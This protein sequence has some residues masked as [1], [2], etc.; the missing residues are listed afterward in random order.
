MM[1]SQVQDM[2]KGQ[3]QAILEGQTQISELLREA[4]STGH[5]NLVDVERGLFEGLL[6][7]GRGALEAYVAA[8]GDGDLGQTVEHE[9]KVLQRLDARSKR[10][11]S[12]FGEITIQRVVYATREGQ[13]HELIPLD[14]V[15][16]L[17]EGDFSHLLQSWDQK[18]CVQN[19]FDRSRLA[20]EEILG[21]G[22]SVR[23]LE[24]MN[25]SMASCAG[26]FR[27]AQAPPPA[28]EEGEILVLTADGKGIPMKRESSDPAPSGRRTKGQ[29]ANK[30]RMACVGAVYSI[31]RFRRTARTVVDDVLRNIRS[32]DRPIP[33]HKQ[34]RAELTREING[35]EC[36]GKD[37]TIGWLVDQVKA[38]QGVCHK[39]VVCVMDGE[40]ALW[41]TLERFLKC[42]I[43]ILD[44]FHVME[45]LWE[46]A[47]CFC[48]EGS[49][50]AR[51]LVTERLERILNGEVGYVVGGLRQMAT[52]RS[53]KGAKRKRIDTVLTYLDNH[54][55]FMKYDRYLA[56]GY[57]IGSGVAEGA[58]RHLVKDRMELTGMRWCTHSAQAMLDLR[59]IF[60]NGDWNE[61][62]DFRI[63]QEQRR[64][65]PYRRKAM[66]LRKAA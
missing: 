19:S 47:H 55:Q 9:G 23:S 63:K 31:N 4:F 32:Q 54:R 40:R 50:E 21:V 61:F 57:P 26:D 49:R 56:A 66:R 58:C 46:A 24:H 52:K 25:A 12:V 37:R 45:R 29:K 10:H 22:Q 3:E 16:G 36:N 44:I 17:P 8:H 62:Q 14:A 35:E 33:Q 43:C 30:K 6:R 64:L 27:E 65:Y 53:L 42:V 34:V 20:I 51:A 13:K 28:E 41:K 60:I 11:V 38:R 5:D 59:A 18:F 2:V 48:D 7:I 15:L 1:I 39:P